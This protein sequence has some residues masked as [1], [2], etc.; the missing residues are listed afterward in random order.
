MDEAGLKEREKAAIEEMN[1][2]L[3]KYNLA[4]IPYLAIGRNGITPQLGLQDVTP[5]EDE[6]PE[7]VNDAKGDAEVVN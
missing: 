7:Q 3:K 4:I 5:K 1:V 6:A 2:I